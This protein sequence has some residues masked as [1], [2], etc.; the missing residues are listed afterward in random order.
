MNRN[1]ALSIAVVAVTGLFIVLVNARA[2]SRSPAHDAS[3]AVLEIPMLVL[4]AVYAVGATVFSLDEDG[5]PRGYWLFLTA[6]FVSI[7]AFIA[8]TARIG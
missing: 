8:G 5:G 2:D 4:L 1:F 6:A 7:V 3:E